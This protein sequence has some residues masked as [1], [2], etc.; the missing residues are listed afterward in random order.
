MI[1]AALS[2]E[3][4][5]ISARVRQSVALVYRPGANGAGTIWTADGQ[6]VTNNHVLGTDGRVEVV[7]ADG[8][9]FVGIVAARHPTRDLAVVKIAANDLPAVEAGDSSTVRPGELVLAVGHP[10]NERDSVTMGVIVASGQAATEQGPETGD[11]L[12]A[13]VTIRPGSSGGPLVD[14]R[15]RV[16]GI[17]AMVAGR[18]ALAIPSQAVQRFVRGLVSDR[19]AA[20]LGLAGLL[21]APGSP[22]AASGF[23]LTDV[24]AGGPAA[25]AGLIVGDIV[26][27]FGGDAVTDESAIRQVLEAAE[28]GMA[29]AVNVL[30]GGEPRSFTVVPTERA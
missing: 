9:H 18:L 22:E 28:P 5:E 7:L 11:Y 23:L 27:R 24:V 2:Q 19:P 8:R 10:L 26:T 4:E 12:Q 14:A 16:I 3:I 30:R 17:N 1:A 15:G 21:V 29:L 20:Y 25:R 13:D 6:V